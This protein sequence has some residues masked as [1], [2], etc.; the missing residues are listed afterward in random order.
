M[1]LCD[2]FAE[3]KKSSQK[4]LAE[5]GR[6]LAEA[7]LPAL[8]FDYRGTGDSGGR[9]EQF[10]LEDWRQ[11]ICAVVDWVRLRW[12]LGRVGLLGLRLGASLAAAEAAR[13]R[14]ATLVMWEPILDGERYAR[15]LGQR[16]KIKHMLTAGPGAANSRQEQQPGFLDLDG[17]LVAPS[18]MAQMAQLRL[19]TG[20]PFPR[21]ALLVQGN[22][23][24]E[25]T[26][27]A[28]AALGGFPQGEAQALQLEPFWQRIGLTDTAPLIATTV[29]WLQGLGEA[30]G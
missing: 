27:E 7:G 5:M 22:A 18:L 30:R 26:P 21:P 24:G 16:S 13:C 8:H 10:N 3:E 28:R 2:P 6:A 23:R 15:E 9:F 19:E 17:Y 4:T 20:E 25:S 12:S 14:A 29:A 11:D 1:V